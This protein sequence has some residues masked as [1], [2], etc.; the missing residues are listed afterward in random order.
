MKHYLHILM[1]HFI[2][3]YK[4]SVKLSNILYIFRLY[5]TISIIFYKLFCNIR[6]QII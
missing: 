5:I 1:Y 3:F 6:I 4:Y 2:L